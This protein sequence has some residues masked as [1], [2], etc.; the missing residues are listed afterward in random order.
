MRIVP[1]S[2]SPETSVS[3]ERDTVQL[4]EERPLESM[5]KEELIELCRKRQDAVKVERNKTDATVSSPSARIK[6]ER[7]TAA[8]SSERPIK[9]ARGNIE[10]IK[11]DD[12]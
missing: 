11:L 1:R 12:D 3:S 9:R 5:S 2:P 7:S 6:H 8:Q 10:V 4:L